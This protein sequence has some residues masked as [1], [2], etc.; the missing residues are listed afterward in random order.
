MGCC[1]SSRFDQKVRQPQPHKK[2]DEQLARK[3]LNQK[4]GQR[5]THWKSDEQ[6]AR[7][8]Q[9]EEN[10]RARAGTQGPAAVAAGRAA[11]SASH[12]WGAAGGRELGGASAGTTAQDSADERRQRALAA[13]ERRQA[14]PSGI[15]AQRAAELRER[16]QKDDLLGRLTE[17]YRKRGLELPMGLNAASAEQLRRHL[18]QV[19]AR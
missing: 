5:E 2:S 12:D 8:L 1:A 6:L 11:Y 10:R 7:K 15:S 3:R 13:A 19:R 14:V 9:E 17:L 16:Q 18:D 4:G